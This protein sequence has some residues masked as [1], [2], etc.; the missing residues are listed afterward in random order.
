MVLPE[1][2]VFDSA[3]PLGLRTSASGVGSG[4]W[5]GIFFAAGLTHRGPWKDGPGEVDVTIAEDGMTVEPGDLIIGDDDG[6]ADR[7]HLRDRLIRLGAVI[8]A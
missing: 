1:L 7:S 6:T 5:N 2:P 4:A 3:R 8:E